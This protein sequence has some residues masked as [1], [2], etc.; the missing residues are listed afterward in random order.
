MKSN[1]LLIVV[2][3]CAGLLLF[4]TFPAAHASRI[5][6]GDE[7]NGYEWQAWPTALSVIP[8]RT[9]LIWN[10]SDGGTIWAAQQIPVTP[11]MW[12]ISFVRKQD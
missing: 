2:L 6:S 9:G 5:D 7:F 3:L 12:G 11:H 8:T 10:T 4:L 1:H